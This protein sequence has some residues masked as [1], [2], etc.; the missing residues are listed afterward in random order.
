MKL[1]EALKTKRG[2][3]LPRR[4]AYKVAH[5]VLARLVPLNASGNNASVR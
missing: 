1:A 3:S 5:K 4:I 2:G